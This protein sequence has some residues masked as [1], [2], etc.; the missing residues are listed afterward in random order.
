MFVLI[1]IQI[2]L[3]IRNESEEFVFLFCISFAAAANDLSKYYS[4]WVQKFI[5][6]RDVK[7]QRVLLL[8]I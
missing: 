7:N 5:I 8:C 1:I 3:K 6:K 2:S 4:D